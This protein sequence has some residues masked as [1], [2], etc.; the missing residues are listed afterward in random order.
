MKIELVKKA[1]EK[2]KIDEGMEQIL[3]LLM[4]YNVNN[5]SWLNDAIYHLTFYSMV[6][7]EE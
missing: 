6:E 4:N 7:E 2:G 3:Q 5:E 1:I